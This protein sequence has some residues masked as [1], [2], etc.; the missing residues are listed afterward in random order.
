MHGG[1][2]HSLDPS[3]LRR[4]V[5][6]LDNNAKAAHRESTLTR[7]AQNT[8]Y[9]GRNDLVDAMRRTAQLSGAF[10]IACPR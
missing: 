7:Q 3:C 10:F 4:R 9:L 6:A 2:V 5:A 8:V 1:I